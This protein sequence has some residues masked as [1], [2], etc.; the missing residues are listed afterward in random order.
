VILG[1]DEKYIQSLPDQT[2]RAQYVTGQLTDHSARV[3]NSLPVDIQEVLLRRDSHG[4][5]PLSQVETER[6]LIDLV[7]DKL[8]LLA[9]RGETK[10]EFSPLGHFFGY[11]GRC[12]LPSNYDADYCYSLGY[13][14]AQLIRAGLTGY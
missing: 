13:A 12:A 1:K 3:Y 6:L 5:V 9:A 2:E 14:A 7:S 10:A 8:R 11:E 4:N